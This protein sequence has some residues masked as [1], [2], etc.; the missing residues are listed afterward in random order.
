MLDY[1]G[2]WWVK[3]LVVAGLTVA[4]GWAGYQA[5]Y[6]RCF[7]TSSVTVSQMREK[8]VAIETQRLTDV[9]NLSENNRLLE[10]QHAEQVAATDKRMTEALRHEAHKRDTIIAD[11]RSRLD[12]LSIPVTETCGSSG[13]ASATPSGADGAHRAELSG[14]AAEFLI[15]LASE[16]DACAVKLTAAQ[17]LI[18]TDRDLRL[19]R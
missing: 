6:D 4:A 3:A 16:A 17:K 7:K 2:L 8:I 5:G 9:T 13:Q 11:L 10:K 14:Q 18:M 12:G 19:T 1:L 15:G